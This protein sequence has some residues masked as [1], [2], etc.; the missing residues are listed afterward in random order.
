MFYA[1]QGV[2]RSIVT[3]VTDGV[4]ITANSL[5]PKSIAQASS[6]VGGM[7]RLEA[8]ISTIGLCDIAV[9]VRTDEIW[10]KIAVR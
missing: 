9:T 7:P 6:G 2:G 1:L 10:G 4:G 5:E 8:Q 3:A